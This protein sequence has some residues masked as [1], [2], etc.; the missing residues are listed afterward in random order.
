MLS[1]E[2]Q[3]TNEVIEIIQG[4]NG[5]GNISF[6]GEDIILSVIPK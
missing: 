3:T 1:L 2:Q 6:G 5:P 4:L